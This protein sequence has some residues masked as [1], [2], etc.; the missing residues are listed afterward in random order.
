MDL[1]LRARL[2]RSVVVEAPEVAQHRPRDVLLHLPSHARVLQADERHAF[3]DRERPERG[4]DAGAE[5]ERRLEPRLAFEELARGIPERAIVGLPGG[6]GRPH[7][8]LRLGQRARESGPPLLGRLGDVEEQL[9][10]ASKRM[11][12]APSA[13]WSPT[14]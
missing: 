4:V 13:T 10:P 12:S 1:P 5:I 9:Q 2:L 8:D 14:P 11:S 7:A 3:R 6:A